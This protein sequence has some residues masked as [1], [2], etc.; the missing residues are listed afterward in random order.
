MTQTTPPNKRPRA[1]FFCA[2]WPNPGTA[3]APRAN[4]QAR[5]GAFVAPRSISLVTKQVLL[6][7]LPVYFKYCDYR[8]GPRPS[9]SKMSLTVG[10]TTADITSKGETQPE[11]D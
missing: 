4:S 10:F 8:S 7:T 9:V 11:S 2:R 1:H 6:R 5:P 3:Q